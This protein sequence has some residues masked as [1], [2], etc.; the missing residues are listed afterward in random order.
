MLQTKLLS[1][2][3][4]R[5]Q[6]HAVIIVLTLTGIWA[7]PAHALF[8]GP[9]IDSSNLAENVR[10]LISIMQQ[11]QQLATQLNH[12]EQMLRSLGTDA[13]TGQQA[14]LNALKSTIRSGTWQSQSPHVIQRQ[15]QG[16]YPLSTH[17]LTNQQVQSMRQRWLQTERIELAKWQ[18][19]TRRVQADMQVTSERVLNVI[20]ASNGTHAANGQPGLTG[21][22]Q[23]RNQLQ[24]I[25][26]AETN[27]LTTLRIM[28][29]KIRAEHRA[30]D[31]AQLQLAKRQRQQIV[32]DW[33]RP[34]AVKPVRPA[35]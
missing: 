25:A 30:R 5:F 19:L 3:K 20:E 35:F 2:A 14:T 17:P 7:R 22:L 13:T 9:V 15:L 6:T 1:P 32:K 8:G 28:R 23:A 21:V 10:Q 12:Q 24:A 18:Q 33:N 29:L 11:M 27:K 34:I 4:H 16:Q 26:A 31:Q